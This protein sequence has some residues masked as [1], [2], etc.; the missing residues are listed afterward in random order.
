M[1]YSYYLSDPFLNNIIMIR[2]PLID[3]PICIIAQVMAYMSG[4]EHDM[5][6]F[7]SPAETGAADGSSHSVSYVVSGAGS[8]VRA[9]EF[10]ELKDKV[11]IAN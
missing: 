1:T 6:Y 7:Q 3:N 9:G 4:H 2:P 10:D 5:Q 11:M 8:D